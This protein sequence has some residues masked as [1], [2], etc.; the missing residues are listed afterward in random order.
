MPLRLAGIGRLLMAAA[1]CHPA[2]TYFPSLRE[3]RLLLV[4]AVE[5]IGH[6]FLRGFVPLETYALENFASA[7]TVRIFLDNFHYGFPPSSG[8]RASIS[9]H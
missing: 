1:A 6:R 5:G 9:I 7:E 4:S 3:T 8:L 2:I